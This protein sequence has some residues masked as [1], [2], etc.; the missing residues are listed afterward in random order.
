MQWNSN[1]NGGFSSKTPWLPVPP[2]YKTYNVESEA[3]DPNSILNMYKKLL[4]LRH[5]NQALLDGAYTALN[6]SDADVMSYLRS[7]K[8]KAV[9]VALNMSA[10]PKKAKFDLG[11]KGF[12]SASLKSLVS[13]PKS[14]AK[15][16]EVSLEPF[17]VFIGEVTK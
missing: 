15:G 13:T 6:K 3:K 14:T 2:T 7:Y 8:G 1:T 12:A 4:A 10:S 17:G 9:L 5:T 16:S 11:D